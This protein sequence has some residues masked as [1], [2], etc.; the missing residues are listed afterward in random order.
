MNKNDITGFGCEV[1]NTIETM[2]NPSELLLNLT[3][4]VKECIKICEEEKTKQLEIQAK[5]N[6]MIKRFEGQKELFENYL[7]KV[8]DERS[9][10][11]K[12]Y[13]KRVDE[14]MR[15]DNIQ[16]MT[17]LLNNMN[18]LAQSAPFAVF[19]NIENTQKALS[20]KNYEWD[21]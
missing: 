7:D 21:F 15:N 2:K 11:F 10:Q 16:Q 8:F 13:F 5:T 20:D 19:S 9:S 14:A 6:E 1:A 12:E 3:E 4:T 17:L 18:A